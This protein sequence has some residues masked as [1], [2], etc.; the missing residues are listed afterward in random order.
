MRKLEKPNRPYLY[1]YTYFFLLIIYFLLKDINL[2]F[3]QDAHTIVEIVGSILSIFI[4][5][6][7]FLH[8]LSKRNNMYLFISTGFLVEGSFKAIHALL[9]SKLLISLA[10]LG[11]IEWTSAISRVVFPSLLLLSYLTWK[12]E[13]S[14]N[15]QG[16]IINYHRLF[17][18]LTLLFVSSFLM[19]LLL[20]QN[21]FEQTTF[22]Y[23]SSYIENSQ[24]LVL[25][26]IPIT[27]Y[28]FA[29]IFYL[30]KGNWKTSKFEHW[31]IISL[32]VGFKAELIFSFANSY[33]EILLSHLLKNTSYILLLVG[34]I[35]TMYQL[36]KRVEES[37]IEIKTMNDSLSK[38]VIERHG[39][40][41]SLMENE[42]RYRLLVEHSPD[43][44]AVNT[45]GKWSYINAAGRRMLAGSS[46]N[47]IIGR[48]IFD[49]IHPDD[50]QDVE[51][52]ISSI[53]E[54][55]C[56]KTNLERRFIT[57]DHR[58]INVEIQAIVTDFLNQQSILIMARD[59]TERKKT[60]ELLRRSEKLAVVGEIAAGIAHEIKNPLTSL[61]GFIQLIQS[62]GID[63]DEYYQIMLSELS[64][65]EHIISELLVLA[66]P[67]NTE[68][69]LKN[70]CGLLDHVIA[71]YR[72]QA[73]KNNVQIIK[74]SEATIPLLLCNEDQLKQV[75][76]NIV[77]NAIEAMP[78]GGLLLIEVKLLENFVRVSFIDEGVGIPDE[79]LRKIGQPFVTTKETGTG[80]GLM[81]SRKIIESHQGEMEIKSQDGQGSR[82]DIY[83][84][85]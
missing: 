1:L 85:L 59:I 57:L 55:G 61:N 51:E 7:A 74:D 66:E 17:I 24:N 79:I 46:K 30:N 20:P 39:I 67:Q 15:A 72:H 80:L 11:I 53:L 10:P 32:I 83:L 16:A 29:I 63:K 14:Q 44:I 81:I 41:E 13:N 22:S 31:L 47:E 48:D 50:Q 23:Q 12:R 42:E 70:I 38:E 45:K 3:D 25:S 77:K 84:P 56:T 28:L 76:I 73:H 19:F 65:I 58:I 43:L 71:L 82:I 33:F 18:Y 4:G 6:L 36:F 68:K 34:L 69:H 27:I 2:G 78:N 54:V 5:I 37:S 60:E 64:R 21:L 26:I 52:T 75:F 62:G 35:H 49:F 8:Y 9:T 40:E